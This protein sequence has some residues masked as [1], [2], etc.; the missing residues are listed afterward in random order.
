MLLLLLLLLGSELQS[1]G[2]TEVG[3]FAIDLDRARTSILT[4]CAILAGDVSEVLLLI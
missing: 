4:L 2:R 1:P 3:S